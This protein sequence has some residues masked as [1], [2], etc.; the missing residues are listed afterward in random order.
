MIILSSKLHL[1]SQE[2]DESAA[3]FGAISALGK[4]DVY[5]GNLYKKFR[6]FLDEPDGKG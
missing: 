4:N 3:A 2:M 6:F 1:I 5:R